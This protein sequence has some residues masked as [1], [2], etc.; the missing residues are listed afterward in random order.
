MATRRDAFTEAMQVELTEYFF[1]KY[2]EVGSK[3]VMFFDE[4]TNDAAYMKFST[5][6]GLGD[7][8]EKPEGESIQADDPMESYTVIC[9]NRTFAR[10]TSMSYE[11]VMDAQKV[12]NAGG[13]FQQAVGTWGTSYPRTKDRWYVKFFNYGAYSAGNDIFNNT[14]SNVIDDSSGNFIYDGKAFFA[15]D[16]PDRV[17][18]TYSNYNASTSLTQANLQ[19]VWLQFT[20]TNAKDERGNEVEIMPDT[21]LIPPALKFTAAVILESAQIPGKMD[22]D[23]NVM[24]SIVEPMEWAHLSDA[25]GW[26]LMKRQAG[27][28]ATKRELPKL[29][30]WQDDDTLDYWA[31]VVSRWGGA[32]S[33]WRYTISNNTSTS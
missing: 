22:N 19:T 25:D 4:V 18:N 20:N 26:F 31:S 10:K 21:L 11:A 3:Y 28:M 32:I 23:T 6:I 13:L 8:L 30:F 29:N 7:L 33:N 16:H 14:I 9:K 24:R 5:A 12:G 27:L 15:T 2:T 1:E 17:G